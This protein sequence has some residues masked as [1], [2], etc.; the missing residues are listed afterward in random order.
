MSLKDFLTLR[1][2]NQDMLQVLTVLQKVRVG[3]AE[4][5]MSIDIK[6]TKPKWI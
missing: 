2:Q 1:L 3:T 4:P 5:E 6:V